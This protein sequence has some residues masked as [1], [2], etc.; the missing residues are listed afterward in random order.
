MEAIVKNDLIIFC[1][2]RTKNNLIIVNATNH[3]LRVK[4]EDGSILE[5]P[6]SVWPTD[7]VLR[8]FYKKRAQV[9]G[10]SLIYL[11]HLLDSS[12]FIN[13]QVSE[14]EVRRFVYENQYKSV[15]NSAI[16]ILE[17]ITSCYPYQDMV[18]VG[19]TV[20]AKTY[21]KYVVTP[22]YIDRE[23]NLIRCN[24]FMSYK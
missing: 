9:L 18:I 21:P 6:S 22:T 15:G 1:R 16:S 5:I 19:T 14:L 20:A 24:K 23:N 3:I 4:E 12:L 2:G 7:D 17:N 8:N 13:V 10:L 11:R